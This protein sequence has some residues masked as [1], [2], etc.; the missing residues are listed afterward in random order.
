ME[1]VLNQNIKAGSYEFNWN[2]G[3]LSSGVFFNLDKLL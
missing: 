3:K 1:Q 2:A